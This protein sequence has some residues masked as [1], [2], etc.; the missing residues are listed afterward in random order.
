[1]SLHTLIG[2]IYDCIDHPEGWQDVLDGIS[3]LLDCH[4]A[5]KAGISFENQ[6]LVISGVGAGMD[7]SWLQMYRSLY[8]TDPWL[9]ANT[10]HTL[11]QVN[12]DSKTPFFGSNYVARS[13]LK[14]TDIYNTVFRFAEAE[15]YLSFP[16]TPGEYHSA[17]V[18]YCGGKKRTSFSTDDKKLS[19]YIGKHVYRAAALADKMNYDAAA[20][21]VLN[22]HE[23][24]AAILISK[25]GCFVSDHNQ[26]LSILSDHYIAKLAGRKL[27]FLQHS[28]QKQFEKALNRLQKADN[29]KIASLSIHEYMKGAIVQLPTIDLE[30]RG[31]FS[32]GARYIL[33][34]NPIGTE[35]LPNHQQGL[36]VALTPSEAEIIHDLKDGYSLSE[37]SDRRQTKYS[38][39]RWHV[40]SIYQKFQ[41]NNQISLLQKLNSSPWVRK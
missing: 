1:M 40:K 21:A 17:L 7:T 38:T 14:K 29:D 24:Q 4:Q 30:S 23:Y 22:K 16:T 41:V 31:G 10:A 28:V 27:V 34:L 12:A 2:D 18:F 26:A 11:R 3:S 8:K 36:Q 15:D 20:T 35:R 13:F 39:T 6:E 37:I 32:S 33:L 19:A 9:M 5:V 25:N